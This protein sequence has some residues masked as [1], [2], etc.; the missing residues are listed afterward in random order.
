MVPKFETDHAWFAK[1]PQARIIFSRAWLALTVIA[2]QCLR[3]IP[4]VHTMQHVTNFRPVHG[5]D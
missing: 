2:S 4:I 1:R 3:W 5:V